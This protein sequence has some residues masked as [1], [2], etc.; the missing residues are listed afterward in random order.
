MINSQLD[1]TE[2][3]PGRISVRDGI[4]WVGLW[5]SLWGTAGLL[6]HHEDKILS[7]KQLKGQR[8]CFGLYL[9]RDWGRHGSWQ[10]RRMAE[11]GDQIVTLYPKIRKQ[12]LNKT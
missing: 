3:H 10:G 11:A 7:P 2:T 9:Q 1:T 8:A 12:R 5:T 4:C 6:F